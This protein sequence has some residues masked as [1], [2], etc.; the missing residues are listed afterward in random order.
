MKILFVVL[1]VSF[2]AGTCAAEF[3]NLNFELATTNRVYS[4]GGGRAGSPD[5]LL[6]GW[7]LK[8]GGSAVTEIAFDTLLPGSPFA[9]VIS[10]QGPSSDWI[11]G[12][13]TLFLLPGLRLG[14]DE[15]VNYSL[16]QEGDVP[17]DARS[18]QF[19]AREF[20]GEFFAVRVNGETLPTTILGS[21]PRGSMLLGADISSYAGTTVQLE[22]AT[23]SRFSSQG[24][25]PHVIDSIR[26]SPEAVPEPGA[27]ALLLTGGVVWWA[28]RARRP[29]KRRA[30]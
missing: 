28:W 11:S 16:A 5:D 3:V 14:T 26:F 7:G 6:P 4:T 21:G 30:V 15:V 1:A 24:F 13:Y 19:D 9:A 29:G 23:Q 18:L 20:F 10:P 2:A 22:L 8:L 12:K 17:A 25:S 27:G